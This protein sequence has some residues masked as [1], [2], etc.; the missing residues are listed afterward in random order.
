MFKDFELLQTQKGPCLSF[1]Y[2]GKRR[3]TYKKSLKEIG[4]AL[5]LSPEQYKNLFLTYK[6]YL[7]KK[8]STL[9][10]GHVVEYFDTESCVNIE[11]D[12]EIFSNWRVENFYFTPKGLLF[13][14]IYKDKP[15]FKFEV[16][17]EQE[18]I[19][20]LQTTLGRNVTSVENSNFVN[21]IY[22][23]LEEYIQATYPEFYEQ[24]IV[25]ETVQSSNFL[26]LAKEIN[27]FQKQREASESVTGRTRTYVENVTWGPNNT[28]NVK[29]VTQP[30]VVNF[31]SF[32]DI[33]N[34]V[35]Q[36]F[37]AEH[38]ERV[39]LEGIEAFT[40]LM[41]GTYGEAIKSIAASGAVT[42]SD[43]TMSSLD[44]YGGWKD[45][46]DLAYKKYNE[47]KAKVTDN[48]T[49]ET[50]EAKV[51]NVGDPITLDQFFH[52]LYGKNAE[53]K[54]NSGQQTA[55]A[56]NNV[57]EGQASP[58]VDIPETSPD[59]KK[60]AL[61]EVELKAIMDAFG[62]SKK[63][64]EKLLS[65]KEKKEKAARREQELLEFK[66]IEKQHNEATKEIKKRRKELKPEPQL[67]IP[68]TAQKFTIA[69]MFMFMMHMV[70]K[71][72][73]LNFQKKKFAAEQ[74][75]TEEQ[76]AQTQT[77]VV[78]ALAPAGGTSAK[79][80]QTQTATKQKV[81][82]KVKQKVKVAR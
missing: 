41:K 65:T 69:A 67:H 82:Q 19:H 48:S 53:E 33:N 54:M 9:P 77:K 27:Y 56:A 15:S 37:R 7:D 58:K 45:V 38:T 42:F 47:N 63:E 68:P 76:Q 2:E 57:P 20:A 21:L 23:K 78:Y 79:K 55:N 8:Y 46:K 43:G 64:A 10:K 71:V 62:V 70:Y 81:A 39:N 73:V 18:I 40:E 59:E 72:A 74:K 13:E 60:A 61:R 5:N 1:E 31:S 32:M 51:N 11:K 25:G 44:P 30:Q 66:E 80:Q 4:K 16:L 3:H 52:L 24:C 75:Q 14:C 22:E 35:A 34:Y 28:L 50:K 49:Q 17:S 12:L 26:E 29:F 36:N 6:D